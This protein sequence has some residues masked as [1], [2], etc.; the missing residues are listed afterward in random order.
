M[1]SGRRSFEIPTRLQ[2][3]VHTQ[4]F[5][6]KSFK[7]LK[8][9][10]GIHIDSSDTVSFPK[11]LQLRLALP[12]PPLCQPA[13]CPFARFRRS[14]GIHAIRLISRAASQLAINSRAEMCSRRVCMDLRPNRRSPESVCAMDATVSHSSH[15]I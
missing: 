5:V 13:A 2:S 11:F 9:H 1:P 6:H 8:V 7:E 14:L 3:T 10:T 4:N 15:D 12:P